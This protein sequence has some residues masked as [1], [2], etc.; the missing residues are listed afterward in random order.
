M[1][2]HIFGKNE[3]RKSTA[4]RPEG[5]G[6]TPK[7]NNLKK[8]TCGVLQELHATGQKGHHTER[9]STHQYYSTSV[10]HQRRGLLHELWDTVHA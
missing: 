7:C 1:Y 2:I 3:K 5:L 4:C 8:A 9:T 6:R 10:F